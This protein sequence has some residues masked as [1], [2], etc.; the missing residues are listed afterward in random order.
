MD[1]RTILEN[2]MFKLLKNRPYNVVR[3]ERD[4]IGRQIMELDKRTAKVEE[5]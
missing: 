5:K 2:K 3:S 4:R 1:K